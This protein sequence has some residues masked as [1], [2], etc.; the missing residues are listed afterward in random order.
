MLNPQKTNY[1]SGTLQA[2]E[3]VLDDVTGHLEKQMET[4]MIVIIAFF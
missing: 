2:R 1:H 4:L 3:A